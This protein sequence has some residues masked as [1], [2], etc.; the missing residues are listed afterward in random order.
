MI[1]TYNGRQFDNEK[2]RNFCETWKIENRYTTPAHPQSNGQVEAVNKVIKDL[3]KKKLGTKK[4]A[5][6]DE[7]PEVL[8]A[9][10]TTF[11]TAT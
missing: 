1:I 9:Y 11:K 6:V 10:R 2:F 4:G 5:W 3:L 8:W 7:L